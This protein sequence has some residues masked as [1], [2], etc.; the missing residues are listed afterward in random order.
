LCKVSLLHSNSTSKIQWVGLIF[1]G[2][3]ALENK[4]EGK[5]GKGKK[6]AALGFD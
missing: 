6:W 4:Q 3:E 2:E 5:M 1:I